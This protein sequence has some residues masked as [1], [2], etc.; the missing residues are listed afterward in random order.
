MF[1]ECCD[2]FVFVLMLSSYPLGSCLL[3]VSLKLLLSCHLQHIKTSWIEAL[4]FPDNHQI[5]K[6]E[7]CWNVVLNI[8]F[9]RLDQEKNLSYRKKGQIKHWK[10]KKLVTLTSPKLSRCNN[11][12]CKLFPLLFYTYCFLNPISYILTLVRNH[13]KLHF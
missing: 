4:T 3:T 5:C 9:H 12:A 6:E 11:C 10:K 13:S 7:I 2:L 8:N 1:W